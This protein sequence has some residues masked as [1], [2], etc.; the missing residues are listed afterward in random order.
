VLRKNPI[1]AE[2]NVINDRSISVLLKNDT[3]TFANIFAKHASRPMT[4]MHPAEDIK[5]DMFE[6]GV[7]WGKAGDLDAAFDEINDQDDLSISLNERPCEFTVGQQRAIDR[8]WTFV[9]KT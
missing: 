6:K 8:I 9:F 7:F 1:I 2:T 4:N 3:R 5:G